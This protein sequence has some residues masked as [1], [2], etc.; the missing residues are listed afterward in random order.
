MRFV[1]FGICS[2][3]FSQPAFVASVRPI[4][5]SRLYRLESHKCSSGG[6]WNQRCAS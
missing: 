3:I 5:P 4:P 2:V 6:T 1:F